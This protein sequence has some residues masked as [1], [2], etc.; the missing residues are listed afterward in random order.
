MSFG[1]N[2]QFLRKMRKGMTQEELAEQLGVSR[3]TISKWELD[4][5]FP[6]V[7]KIIEISKLFSCSIDQ[8]VREDVTMIEEAYS[9]I[10]V[11]TLDSF[12]FVRYAVVSTD[13]ESDAIIHLRDWAHRNEI[14]NPEF[15]GWDFPWVSQEQ[16]NVHNMHGYEAACILPENFKKS[17]EEL[18]MRNQKQ[19]Q[20]S[21]ITIKEPFSAPFYLI[22]NAYKTLMMYL[23]INDYKQGKNK[24]I[25]NCFEKIYEK[26]GITY[27]D[28][29]I[30][31]ED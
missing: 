23:E 22:P 8:L 1:Q 11:K 24:D 4:N 18:E 9:N 28:V 26:E 29:Y 14:N 31:V 12:S 6:E 5:T 20:Y 15:I 17:C 19:Q 3:Q 27:M 2:V 16:I 7:D 21:I 13:P 25:I 10:R 30:S